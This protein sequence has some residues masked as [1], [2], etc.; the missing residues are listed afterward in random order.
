MQ[1]ELPGFAK[2]PE[3]NNEIDR[4]HE[5]V[6]HLRKQQLSPERIR[7]LFCVMLLLEWADEHSKEPGAAFD[8]LCLT[9]GAELVVLLA[10]QLRSETWYEPSVKSITAGLSDLEGAL[11]SAASAARPQAASC[12]QIL[13]RAVGRVSTLATND[14]EYASYLLSSPSQQEMPRN[15]LLRLFDEVGVTLAEASEW[16]F[17]APSW[18]MQAARD[19]ADPDTT[20]PA[21]DSTSSPEHVLTLVSEHLAA[22]TVS[23]DTRQGAVR[24]DPW[25]HEHEF[26]VGLTRRVLREHA[27]ASSKF[28]LILSNPPFGATVARDLRRRSDSPAGVMHPEHFFIEQILERLAP[29]KRAVIIVP[30]GFL[31]RG[32]ATGLRQRL[33]MNGHLETVISLPQQTFPKAPNV[34]TAMLVLINPAAATL[35]GDDTARSIQFI[36]GS[37]LQR[38]TV[39]RRRGA[40]E[41][42]EHL[43]DIRRE[44]KS[45]LLEISYSVRSRTD[46]P[47][48]KLPLD[49]WL[50]PV[51]E[52][53]AD[54]WRMPV[55][56]RDDDKPRWLSTALADVL[57]SNKD[58]ILPL[59]RLAK[60]RAGFHVKKSH[61]ASEGRPDNAIGYFRIAD[62][63]NGRANRPKLWLPYNH[64]G[65][66]QHRLSVGDILLSRS[67]TV[68]KAAVLRGDELPAIAGGGLYVVRV[69][70]ERIDPY[71]LVAYLHSAWCRDWLKSHSVRSLYPNLCIPTLEEL[72][73]PLPPLELQAE[74]AARVAQSGQD[75]L[76]DLAAAFNVSLAPKQQRTATND[77]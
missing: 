11:N 58:A 70:E 71:F 1:L 77:P 59:A 2:D 65:I 35:D 42:L 30:A 18:V 34:V 51:N 6:S 3:N 23:G 63:S 33:V 28:D 45:S 44:P 64:P 62:L 46:G 41:P 53:Q 69:D 76:V 8:G 4:L 17:R 38:P 25:M 21:D 48:S 39:K 40:S 14:I 73:V 32:S 57:E 67:G 66:S 75:L 10:S 13:S 55:R 50:V 22:M 31:T 52:L 16:S 47:T 37:P 7:E 68:D 61:L 36:D 20:Q 26:L 60:I 15:R 72:D 43:V 49:S 19:I 9:L 74:L 5:F 12:L 24:Y 29:G 27:W 54:E 56:K